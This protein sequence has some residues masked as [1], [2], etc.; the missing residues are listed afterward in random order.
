MEFLFGAQLPILSPNVEL[1]KSNKQMCDLNQNRALNAQLL[2]M[3]LN[4]ISTAMEASLRENNSTDV[5]E[6]ATKAYQQGKITKS[7][8]M[9]VINALDEQQAVQTT[10]FTVPQGEQWNRE[11]LAANKFL[12][13]FR[14]V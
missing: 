4:L 11:Y 3:G 7:Q 2:G 13:Q 14:G 5:L 6:T 1:R 9:A 8:F 10:A 12:N